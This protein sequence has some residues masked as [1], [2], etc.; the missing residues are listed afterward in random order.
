M[1]CYCCGCGLIVIYPYRN[2]QIVRLLNMNI[3]E[4]V[5]VQSDACMV[6]E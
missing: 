5:E 6:Y 1:A 3:M 4:H 2:D